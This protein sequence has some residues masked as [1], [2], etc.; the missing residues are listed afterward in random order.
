MKKSAMFFPVFITVLFLV[1]SFGCSKD[2]NNPASPD[3]TATPTPITMPGAFDLDDFEDG[4]GNNSVAPENN[5]WT[6]HNDSDDG[7]TSEVDSAGTVT[8][9]YNGSSSYAFCITG[10]VRPEIDFYSGGPYTKMVPSK[11]GYINLRTVINEFGADISDSVYIHFYGMSINQADGYRVVITDIYGR[12][13]YKY[14]DAPEG[15][16]YA[17]SI[18]FSDFSL[19]SGSSYSINDVLQAVKTITFSIRKYDG[20]PIT[21]ELYIDDISFENIL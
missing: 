13:A 11:I 16:Y 7:G 12:Y 4:D 3:P 14:F 5:P 20:S 1:F 21:T 8:G 18:N 2:E 19:P 17:N 15:S 9:G 10:T 6:S